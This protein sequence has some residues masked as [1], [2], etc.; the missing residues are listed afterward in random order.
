M[1]RAA[2]AIAL[3]T[4]ALACTP[5]RAAPPRPPP[6]PAPVDAGVDGPAAPTP[7]ADL[8][9]PPGVGPRGYQLTLTIDP[10]RPTFDG[11]VAIALAVTT[12]T[13]VVWLHADALTIDAAELRIG[14]A[15]A[16][17]TVI[18]DGAHQRIGLAHAAAIPDGA[19]LVVRYRGGIVDDDPMGL[20]RQRQGSERY[21]YSQMEGVFARRVVP[22]FDE[23][24][25]KVPWQLTVRAPAG[26]DVFANAPERARAARGGEQIVEFAPTPPMASYLLA[27]AVGR[28]EQ[29]AIG[30]VGRG[31]VP[32]RVLTPIGLSAQAAAAAAATPALVAWLEAYFDRP[33]PLAKL[34]LVAVPQFFGAMENPGLILFASSILLADP[35]RPSDAGRRELR[36]VVAHELAHQWFGDLVTPRWWDDLWLNES[37]ATWMAAA[38]VHALDPGD[39]R[40]TTDRAA[41]ERAMAADQL[42]SARPLRRPIAGGLDVDDSFDAIAY[43]KG[44]ALVAMFERQLGPDRF[45]AGVRAYLTAHAGGNA[46]AA[47]FVAALAAV[48][49][50][51]VAPAFASFLDHPGVPTVRLA[52]RCDGAGAEV[53]ATLASDRGPPPWTL[54]LCVR[55]PDA[56]GGAEERCGWLAAAPLR[57]PLPRCPAWLIGNPGGAGYLRVAYPDDLDRALRTQLARLDVRDRFARAA[58]LAAQV[59]T[60]EVAPAALPPWI[61]ALLATREPHDALAAAALAEALGD[62]VGATDRPRWQRFVRARFGA[63]ARRLGLRTRAGDDDATIA[64]RD[65]LVTLVGVDG[66]DPALG[67]AAVVAVDRWLRGGADPGDDRARLLAIAMAAAPDRL[68]DRVVAAALAAPDRDTR[69]DFVAALAQRTTDR[70]RAANLALFLAGGIDAQT[71]LP[72]VTDGLGTDDDAGAWA[73]LTA[74]YDL[75]A[76]RL[77][78]LDRPAI[79]AAAAARC[80]SAARAEVAAFFAARAVA[81][82]RVALELTPAL[83]AIDRCVAERARIQPALPALLPR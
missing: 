83:E 57:L 47:D 12:P 60:G 36:A 38:A 37:F 25:F 67:R 63:A 20:F 65:Q 73:T 35:A 43:E 1:R 26:L 16:P 8:R 22:C 71:A 40:V 70:D 48:A 33:L 77:T 75:I 64:A 54:P 11:E 3:T 7:P 41:I 74:S 28:F 6:A 55:F 4:L 46:S 9:S 14:A 50:P 79:A 58:D 44:G 52:L 78:L 51:E 19:T 53:T 27:V 76:A 2:W 13:P 31:A 21:V 29:V 82:P 68:R 61:D 18:A 23:P 66:H 32:A 49:E 24:G 39:D 59:R 42:P 72:L 80:T 30:P 10:A 81:D 62:H 34:D 5:P 69:A 45:R 15:R 17:L 56:R